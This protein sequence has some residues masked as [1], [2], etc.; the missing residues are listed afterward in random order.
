MNAL[1]SV[2]IPAWNAQETL[3][4]TLESVAAQTHRNIE[5]II[6]DD[7]S[8]DGTGAIAE[9]FCDREPRARLIRQDN[10]GVASARNLGIE[11]A[12]GSFVAPID[13]DDLWHPEKL[14]RQADALMRAPDSVG[15]AYNWFRKID[16]DGRV[17]EAPFN[18]VVEGRVFDEHLRW[19]FIANGSTP[20]FRSE[21]LRQFRYSPALRLAG[22][23][24]CEDYL[25][26]LQIASRFEF[27]CVPAFLT[28]YRASRSNMSA[29]VERMIRS[30]IQ[31]Y[32]ILR[33]FKGE[34]EA[35]SIGIE[36]ARQRAAL[37]LIRLRHCDLK[38]AA[39]ALGPA[40]I[41][42]PGHALLEGWARVSRRWSPL[43]GRGHPL[44]GR[45]FHDLSPE[46]GSPAASR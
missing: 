10:A 2:I 35:R 18:P 42:S 4:E 25:L 33:E 24:G 20:M 38:A 44:I 45:H 3:R 13:A 40:L 46:A 21:V 34:G 43:Q 41:A 31:M 32:E 36:L 15:L 9:A 29:D 30:H 28:G 26:Q 16:R 22:N 12:R 19:N 23:E 14:E 5:I 8:T 27:A 6:V 37:G 39:R 11:L 7:G 17:I 1:V